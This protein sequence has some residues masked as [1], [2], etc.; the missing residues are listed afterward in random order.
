MKCRSCDTEIAFATTASGK[1]S[2]FERDDAGLWVIE[3]GNARYVGAPAREKPQLQLVV[4]EPAAQ[5]YTSHFAKCPEAK[6]WRR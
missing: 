1:W 2:P 6:Q 4:A 3:D 5:R